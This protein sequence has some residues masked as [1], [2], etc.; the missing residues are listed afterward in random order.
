MIGIL[1]IVWAHWFADFIL[2][3]DTMAI[4]KS[5]SNKWLG[6]HCSVYLWPIFLLGIIFGGANGIL[7][8]AINAIAHFVVDYFTSRG[9]SS[10][11]KKNE[12]HWFF[13]LIGFD[14]AIHMTILLVTAKYMGVI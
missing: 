7:W 4:N 11:W 12:R 13:V 5:S 6:I 2:Q 8:A 1:A 3:N 10:L 9:T 14:Q